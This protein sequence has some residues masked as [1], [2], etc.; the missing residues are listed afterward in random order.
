MTE[1]EQS[2]AQLTV[3]VNN[4]ERKLEITIETYTDI[5]RDLSQALISGE[6]VPQPV[7]YSVISRRIDEA[8]AKSK[9]G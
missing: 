5:I 3:R 1:Q 7:P 9:R 6:Q 2:I 8:L 4:L